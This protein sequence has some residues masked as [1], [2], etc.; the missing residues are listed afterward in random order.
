M[1]FKTVLVSVFPFSLYLSLP[2][3]LSLSLPLYLS[4]SAYFLRVLA[5]LFSNGKFEKNLNK[6]HGE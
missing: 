4:P 5:L 1:V 2:L 6:K 3:S